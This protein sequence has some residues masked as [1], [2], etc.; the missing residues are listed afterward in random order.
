MKHLKVIILNLCIA[1]FYSNTATAAVTLPYFIAD[2]MVLQQQAQPLIWGWTNSNKKV[3][4]STSWNKKK[5]TVTANEKGKWTINIETPIA[6]GPYEMAISDGETITLKNILIGEVWLCS[7]Q[8][9]MEM[10]MKGF[11]DQPIIGSNEAIFNSNNDNIRLFIVPRSVQRTQQDTCKKQSWKV[12]EPEAVSNFSATAYYFGKVLHDK[13]KVP[14]GLISISY[15]GSPIEAF[16]D[17]ASLASFADIKL[18]SKTDTTKKINNGT[19]TTLYNGMLHPFLGFTVKGC[20][21]YQGETNNSR[22]KQYETLFP[23]FI[24]MLRTKCNNDSLPFYY[25]QIAPYNYTNNTTDSA[26][27]FNSA[28]LRDAQ[29]KTLAKIPNSGMVVLMDI[30]EEF[31]IHPAN[32]ETGSKR[33]AYM[34]LAKTYQH[35]GFGYASPFFDSLLING[36]VATVKFNNAVNGLTSYGKTLTN[37]EIAGENKVYRPARAVIYQGKVLVSSPE[38]DKPVAVR[39]AFK[40]FVVGELFNTE[41]FPASSFRTDNW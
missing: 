31:N 23:A 38:I 20:I 7:G 33:F 13:L 8:S 11:R 5:Y 39:Y 18:P 27:K 36:N 22:A 1:F 14:V 19:P 15:G 10:P 41:G 34:A 30:G 4:I 37:F 9:N 3:T 32:K 16:M 24:Q 21:W 35:K 12:A 26:P 29:R 28:Y 17:E 6:G 25:A 40:D 2:N